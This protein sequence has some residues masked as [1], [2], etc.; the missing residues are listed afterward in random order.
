MERVA[1]YMGACMTPVMIACRPC[2]DGHPVHIAFEIGPTID[3][4]DTALTLTRVA[5]GAGANAIKVQLLRPDRLIGRDTEVTYQLADGETVTESMLAI[6]RR[7]VLTPDEWKAVKAEADRCGLAFIATVDVPSSLAL[8]V[9]LGAHALKICSGDVTMLDWI[10]EVASMG[11]PVLLDTGHATLGE[12][13]RAVDVALE[14]GAAGVVLHIVPTGYPARLESINLR[15]ITT[16]RQV[17]GDE[18]AIGFSD[19]TP[20]WNIDLAAVALGAHQIEKTLTLD[21]ATRGPEHMMSIDPQEAGEFVRAIRDV[22]IALGHPRRR[23]TPEERRRKQPARRSA[24][25]ARDLRIG[26]VITESAIEWRRPGDGIAPAELPYLVG[27]AVRHDLPAGHEIE[28][29]DI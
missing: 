21:R 9:D 5:G 2:G 16:M 20:G 8:A 27:R 14:G 11:G 29:G 1:A 28:R 4:V 3:S 7:R 12:I 17:F 13:E 24:F 22:E 6:L 26:Q 18:I 10:A 19:H 15:M 25:L 23:F